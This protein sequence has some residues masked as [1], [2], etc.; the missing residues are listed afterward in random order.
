MQRGAMDTQW[1]TLEK[2]ALNPRVLMLSDSEGDS[3]L[4]MRR[5]ADSLLA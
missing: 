3:P 2:E 1:L 4:Q 5:S